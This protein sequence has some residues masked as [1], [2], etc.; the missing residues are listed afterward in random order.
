VDQRYDFNDD[1]FD[2][3]RATRQHHTRKQQ[4]S[5]HQRMDGIPKVNSPIGNTDDRRLGG[6]PKIFQKRSDSSPAAE[7]TVL[8]SGLHA[9]LNTR[10]VWPV[11]SFTFVKLDPLP[12]FQRIS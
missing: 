5:P 3:E 9:R 8:P 10:D 4:C 6:A 2:A 7:T 1:A 12:Y 11:S